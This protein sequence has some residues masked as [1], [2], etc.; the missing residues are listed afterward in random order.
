LDSHHDAN[1]MTPGS[2]DDKA[3]F[4]HRQL[5]PIFGEKMQR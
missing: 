4:A 2:H 1:L 3:G 5:K